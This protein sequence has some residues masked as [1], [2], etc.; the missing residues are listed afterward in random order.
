MLPATRDEPQN[1]LYGIGRPSGDVG[2]P[3]KKNWRDEKISSRDEK[4]RSVTEKFRH[5]SPSQDWSPELVLVISPQ[6]CGHFVGGFARSFPPVAFTRPT[7]KTVVLRAVWVQNKLSLTLLV[8]GVG[9]N[10]GTWP[11]EALPAFPVTSSSS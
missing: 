2:A 10:G 4:F 6:I 11:D 9:S 5:A 3:G 8:S 1:T 7:P